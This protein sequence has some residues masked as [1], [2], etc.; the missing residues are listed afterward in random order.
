MLFYTDTADAPW[1]I[2][3]SDDKKRARLNAIKYLLNHVDYAG[4]DHAL[5]SDMDSLV[6]GSAKTIYER[7]EKGRNSADAVGD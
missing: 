1:T 3:R 4:K 7:G 6:V 5:L 2:V